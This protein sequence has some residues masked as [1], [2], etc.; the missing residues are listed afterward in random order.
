MITG[1]IIGLLGEE[2]QIGGDDFQD[3]A[4]ATSGQIPLY[5]PRPHAGASKWS[6]SGSTTLKTRDASTWAAGDGH[7]NRRRSPP[8]TATPAAVSL[9]LR[10]RPP[11]Y[12]AVTAPLLRLATDHQQPRRHREPRGL[13]PVA[14]FGSDEGE[15][16][17]EKE[18]KWERDLAAAARVAREDDPG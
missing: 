14:S 17:V 1:A 3:D 18:A 2:R 5:W 8:E 4:P 9:C 11:S 6:R 7:T 10:A 16:S 13:C 12:C 15:Q